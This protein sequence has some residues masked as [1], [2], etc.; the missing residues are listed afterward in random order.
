LGTYY[1][2][3]LGFDINGANAVYGGFEGPPAPNSNLPA[4]AQSQTWLLSNQP[5]TAKTNFT[6]QDG[7]LVTVHLGDQIYVRLFPTDELSGPSKAR[8]ILVVGRKHIDQTFRTPF[9]VGQGSKNAQT[10]LDSGDLTDP[11]FGDGSSWLFGPWTIM[12]APNIQNVYLEF[13]FI[14]G[15]HILVGEMA[16]TFGH[17]PE[18]N[19]G[20]GVGTSGGESV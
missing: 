17:D 19:V 5:P 8:S 6:I 16:Y 9:T 12:N 15:A 3:N 2:L 18:M 20:M 7:S 1:T 13:R 14:S 4:L 11:N 10:I